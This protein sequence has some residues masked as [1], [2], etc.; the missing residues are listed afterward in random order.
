MLATCMNKKRPIFTCEIDNGNIKRILEILDKDRLPIMLQ[1]RMT[2]PNANKWLKT[3]KIPDNR[4]G[5]KKAR[6]EFPRFESYK[7]M[8]SLSDQYWFSYKKTDRWD[9]LNYFTNPFSE[10]LGRI[11][12]EPWTVDERPVENPDLTTNGVLR[13]R[14]IS[15]NDKQYLIKAGSRQ[16][17]QD[18]ISEVLA[19]MTLEQIDII[20]FVNYSL[21]V[22]GLS[23]CCISENFID[24]D[25]EYVPAIQVFEKEFWDREKESVYEHLVRTS[26]KYGVKDAKDFIDRMICADHFICNTDRHLG[27]FGYIRDA[28]SGEIKGFAPLF[29]CGSAFFGTNNESEHFRDEEKRCI[30]AYIGEISEKNPKKDSLVHLVKCY[31]S[32][33]GEQEKK[34]ISNIKRVYNEL[35]KSSKSKLDKMKEDDYLF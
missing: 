22:D 20:P 9:D 35:K 21:V 7:H 10:E 2:I 8:F 27:N 14:W 28:E 1:D 33:N 12:F 29:D 30:K 26:E 19:S 6:L 11:F 4:E 25:T 32:I 17:H 18:P 16:Y 24:E 23:L 3:R 15:R 5:I 34:I 31:P 13:K